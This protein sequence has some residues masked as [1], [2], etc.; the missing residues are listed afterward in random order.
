M[1]CGGVVSKANVAAA[2]ADGSVTEAR[3][4]RSLERLFTIRLR[5]GDFD[6]PGPQPYRQIQ[7]YG[8]AQIHSEANANLAHEAAVQ[9]LVL[10]KNDKETLPLPSLLLGKK[11]ALLGPLANATQIL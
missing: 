7:N 6:P 11:I 5:L 1:N 3:L 4:R 8:P 9:S 2:L 10:L